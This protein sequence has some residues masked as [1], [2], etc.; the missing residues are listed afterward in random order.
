MVAMAT[1]KSTPADITEIQRQ[2]AQIRR[3][4]HEDV[5]EAVK[6]AQELT[7]WRSRVRSHPWMALGAAAA[8]GYVI[9]PRRHPAPAPAIVAVTPAAAIPPT[10]APVLPRKKRSG[11]IGSAIGLLA[12]IAVRA[13]QNFAIQYLEHW[14]ASRPPGAGSS[15]LGA[16][17]FPGAP[18]AGGGP[19]PNPRPSP[20]HGTSGRPRDAR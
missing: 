15:L 7:D 6:G 14:I 20:P 18:T 10:P 1:A 9:V 12:P 17:L 11:L 19:G 16:G 8:L 13:A 3:E 4:L 5:R 2:M